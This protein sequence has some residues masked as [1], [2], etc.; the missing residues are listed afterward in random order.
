LPPLAL[1]RRL[2]EALEAELALEVVI[3]D[4][5]DAA[6][7]LGRLASDL[8][9]VALKPARV[10]VSTA[11]DLLSWQPGQPRPEHP[12]PELICAAARKA[13][14]EAL[15]GG[16][17]FSYFTELN[18]KRPPA[19]LFDYISHTTCPIVHAAD[20]RS[21]METLESLPA[22]IASTKA[23]VAGTPYRVGPSAISCRDNPYGKAPFENP[24]NGRVCL[25]A[26]DPRQRGLFG[27]AF[28]LGYVAAFARG[29]VEAVALGAPTGPSGFIHRRTA[30]PQPGFDELPVR[31][32]Y[33]AF[34]V[35]AG[36]AGGSGRPLLAIERS[37]PGAVDAI[38]WHEGER[39]VLWLANLTDRAVTIKLSGMQAACIAVLDCSSFERAIREPDAVGTL[40]AGVRCDPIILEAYAVARIT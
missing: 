21:V 15:L 40:S 20:D 35:M 3:P 34:H 30:Y 10:A 13:F 31:A 17:M 11:S 1:F 2:S 8:A 36:L 16:G 25:A 4:D 5:A 28:A 37:W 23:F 18:R 7:E 22:I 38:A 14:P 33:P 39:T 12:T 24:E 9:A 26:M 29:S 6:T 19:G 32:V 27:A